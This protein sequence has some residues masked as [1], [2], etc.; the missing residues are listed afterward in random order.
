MSTVTAPARN[1]VRE[2]INSLTG[3]GKRH[4][5]PTAAV[6]AVDPAKA[7]KWMQ[8][9]RR[10]RPVKKAAVAKYARDMRNGAWALNGEPF[11]FDTDGFMI[12]GQ[13][14]ALAVIESGATIRTFVIRNIPSATFA[15]M[16]QGVKRGGGDHMALM[17]ETSPFE[18][19]TALGHLRRYERGDLGDRGVNRH[20]SG[21]EMVECLDRHPEMRVSV[22]K[23][24]GARVCGSVGLFAFLHFAF[25]RKDPQLADWFLRAICSGEGLRANDAVY[26]LRERLIRARGDKAVLDER[27]VLALAITAWNKHRAGE[28]VTRLNPPETFPTIE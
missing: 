25:S 5:D 1:A 15:T 12:D 14:R 11:K 10:N 13:H 23:S 4:V 26:R 7:K 20:V 27:I 28:K 19:A 17:G 9:N 18:L 6:E 2:A 24:L 8:R 3:N 22:N 16:D 21:P